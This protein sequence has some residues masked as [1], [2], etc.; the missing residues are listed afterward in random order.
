M[1]ELF[2]EINGTPIRIS[3]DEDGISV[4]VISYR[5]TELDGE[6]NHSSTPV[7]IGKSKEG[8]RIYLGIAELEIEEGAHIFLCDGKGDK[9]DC[10]AVLTIHKNGLFFHPCI[11]ETAVP[12][13]L[14]TAGRIDITNI[15]M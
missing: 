7:Y 5:Y 14:D 3:V 15:H 10:G 12:F 2:K 1:Q 11:D 9:L 8:L 6:N 4:E 13:P